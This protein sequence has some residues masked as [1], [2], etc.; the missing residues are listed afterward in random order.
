MIVVLTTIL[1]VVILWGVSVLGCYERND[2]EVI[3][4]RGTE[5]TVRDSLGFVWKFKGEG[6]TVGDIVTLVMS[7]NGTDSTFSDDKVIKVK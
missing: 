1:F 7:P 4:V 5:V 2:C 3:G 6:Y